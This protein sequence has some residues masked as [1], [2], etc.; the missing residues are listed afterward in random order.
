MVKSKNLQCVMV[1]NLLAESTADICIGTFYFIFI[2]W[3]FLGGMGLVFG[4]KILY[5]LSLIC[6]G[7]S[8]PKYVFILMSRTTS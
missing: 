5:K 7:N 8:P 3:S 6:T 2:F 4:K 1:W